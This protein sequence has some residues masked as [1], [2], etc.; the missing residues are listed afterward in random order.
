MAA[1]IALAT[2]T[3][4]FNRQDGELGMILNC[5]GPDNYEVVTDYGIEVWMEEDIQVVTE[6]D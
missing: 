5:Y 6:E 3:K 2:E 4:V 1:M